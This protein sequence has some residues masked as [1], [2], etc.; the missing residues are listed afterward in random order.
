MLIMT[1]RELSGLHDPLRKV[2]R[3]TFVTKAEDGIALKR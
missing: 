1:E 2:Q 3:S